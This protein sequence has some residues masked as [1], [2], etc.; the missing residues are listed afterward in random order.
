MDPKAC[1][2]GNTEDYGRELNECLQ[3]NEVPLWQEGPTG[4]S[5]GGHWGSAWG[6]WAES[7][8]VHLGTV[9]EVHDERLILHFMKGSYSALAE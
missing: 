7:A 8:A 6:G 9:L 5:L 1:P 4:S 2:F 3:I